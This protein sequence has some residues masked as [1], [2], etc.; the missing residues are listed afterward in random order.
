MAVNIQCIIGDNA[1]NAFIKRI[2]TRLPQIYPDADLT[3][4]E[5]LVGKLLDHTFGDLNMLASML[6][7][8]VQWLLASNPAKGEN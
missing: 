1:Q 5:P 7:V 4:V 6:R 2:K 3:T 8:D